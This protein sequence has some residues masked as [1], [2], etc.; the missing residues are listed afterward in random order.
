M[1]CYQKSYH[2]IYEDKADEADDISAND[3]LS[4]FRVP[5]NVHNGGKLFPFSPRV[6]LLD[7]SLNDIFPN[8]P[9]RSLDIPAND[10]Y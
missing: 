7:A 1:F 4:S 9:F 6:P 8:I 10:D 2:M 3:L 5:K